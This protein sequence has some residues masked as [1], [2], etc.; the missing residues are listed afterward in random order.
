MEID[1][2][3]QIEASSEIMKDEMDVMDNIEESYRIIA[4]YDGFS[5]YSELYFL[6]IFLEVIYL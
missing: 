6:L 2:E 4:D 5:D 3:E 1:L